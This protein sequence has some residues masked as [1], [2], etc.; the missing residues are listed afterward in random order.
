MPFS[1][2]PDCA[3]QAAEPKPG[4][5]RPP[6][7][8]LP[9]RD[10]PARSP[11]RASSATA[12]SCPPSAS[13]RDV[14]RRRPDWRSRPTTCPPKT[15]IDADRR[16]GSRSTPSTTSSAAPHQEVAFPLAKRAARQLLPRRRRAA[17]SSRGS[18]RSCSRIAERWLRRVRR[19]S[20]T[21]PSRSC[22]CSPSTAHDAA[23]RIYHA[24]VAGTERREARSCRSCGPTTRSARPATSTSTRPSTVYATDADEVPHLSHVV[25]DTELGGE[26]GPGARGDGR[27]RRLRQ[28][29]GPR[30]HD[31]V[32]ARRRQQRT[33]CPTSS[34]ASTTADGPDDR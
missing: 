30:L 34:S 2:H 7:R 28:E 24:I 9:E 16:R 33:T 8:A 6:V 17:P 3:A 18:S 23:E 26:A 21:T 29:P 22:C 19:R 11:S 15:E 20:R 1:L 25:A 27:G 14:H 4:R 12:T 13:T 10:R 5:R 32:H 31:P